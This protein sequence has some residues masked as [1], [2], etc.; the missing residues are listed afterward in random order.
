MGNLIGARGDVSAE[1]SDN[2][3]LQQVIQLLT[4]LHA[5]G[6]LSEIISFLSFTIKQQPN[7]NGL[8]TFG[9]MTICLRL[10]QFKF[11]IVPDLKA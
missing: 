7:L 1:Y 5:C 9:T 8:N 6:L 4:G 3:G 11:I 2:S 10:G